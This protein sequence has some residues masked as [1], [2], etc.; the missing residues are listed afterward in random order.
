M[1]DDYIMT[2]TG[3]RM[4]PLQ[5]DPDDIDIEDIAHALSN[6][7]RFSGHV[8]RFYSVAQHSVLVSHFCNPADALWGLLHDAPEAYL[9]DL[10]RPVKKGL[11]FHGNAVY[12]VAEDALMDC[13]CRKFGLDPEMPVSVRKA[14]DVMLA[15]EAHQL[16]PLD[17]AFLRLPQSP[18]RGS[19]HCLQPDAAKQLF[20]TRFSLL[21]RKVTHASG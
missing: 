1:S 2:F 19:L 10:P 13:V 12:D 9:L 7:C 6:L 4:R 21:T 11:R 17:E 5:P 20:L 15:T 3:K 16:M 8:R 14:D 18:L